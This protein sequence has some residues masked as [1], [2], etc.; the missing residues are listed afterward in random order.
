MIKDFSIDQLRLKPVNG[1][2][3]YIN[4]SGKQGFFVATSDTTSSDDGQDTIINQLSSVR[5][6]REAAP[7]TLGL[8]GNVLYVSKL[9]G[10][11]LTAEKGNRYKQ[12]KD[13]WTAMQASSA[14]DR[15]VITDD[16]TYTVGNVG[17][18]D[19]Y[20]TDD[21]DEQNLAFHNRTL[22]GDY[23]ATI[24]IGTLSTPGYLFTDNLGYLDDP[25]TN[26][27]PSS[28]ITFKIQGNLNFIWAGQYMANFYH[29]DTDI[30]VTCDSIVSTDNNLFLLSSPYVDGFSWSSAGTYPN[31]AFYYGTRVK[32]LKIRTK[33]LKAADSYYAIV[34]S[35]I[36]NYS[37]NISNIP[38][39][40]R[41]TY[42]AGLFGR[43]STTR[44]V[45]D[46][47]AD[48]VYNRRGYF[49][50]LSNYDVTLNYSNLYGTPWR[51]TARNCYINID[52]DRCQPNP[53]AR[54][55]QFFAYGGGIGNIYDVNLGYG[56]VDGG[57]DM[58][59]SEG[60][61]S[62]HL[63]KVDQMILSPTST[64]TG[65]AAAGLDLNG[66]TRFALPSDTTGRVYFE[67]NILS[68]RAGI[69]GIY[70]SNDLAT[71]AKLPKYLYISNSRIFVEA[72]ANSIYS[73]V[74]NRDINFGGGNVFNAIMRAGY[75]TSLGLAPT[76][77]TNIPL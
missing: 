18:G 54:S 58:I 53:N 74:T 8:E 21:L 61:G 55:N 48:T 72:T 60:N 70:V 14:G 20:E 47:K 3:V 6:K 34:T 9:Y 36:L 40:A 51:A 44:G 29:E 69:H 67:G 23:G 68:T 4:D 39:I 50:C 64:L 22:I 25:V 59:N 30:D 27:Y 49:D 1:E 17:S 24:S 63:F 35:G 73:T 31:D 43:G 75:V 33:L 13:P 57:F 11:N 41:D 5:W 56:E 52:V 46:I 12:Y 10:N 45:I 62:L 66:S 28:G 15:I 7:S 2:R 26:Y 65:S 37:D 42:D 16:S 77:D 38:Q 32:R 19:T 76:I 71:A